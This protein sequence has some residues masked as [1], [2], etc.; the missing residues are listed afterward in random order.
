M[1]FWARWR[2]WRTCVTLALTSCQTTVTRWRYGCGRQ[3]MC[4]NCLFRTL[5]RV[6][7]GRWFLNHQAIVFSELPVT[8]I[9]VAVIST[10]QLSRYV[11]QM[12]WIMFPLCFYCVSIHRL[13]LHSIVRIEKSICKFCTCKLW[14]WWLT[15]YIVLKLNKVDKTIFC[16]KYSLVR[17][18]KTKPHC[19]ESLLNIY[20]CGLKSMRFQMYWVYIRGL[21]Q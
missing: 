11:T 18:K 16:L 6:H 5:S 20:Y 1:I 17:Y 3:R 12:S 4:Q 7:V 19:S 8:K 9:Q 15:L 14:I 13:S 21:S 2:R 10:S